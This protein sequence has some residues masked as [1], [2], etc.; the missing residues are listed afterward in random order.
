MSLEEMFKVGDRVFICRKAFE[1]INRSPLKYWQQ[2]INGTVIK[3]NTD[4]LYVE[5]PEQDTDF[6]GEYPTTRAYVLG[7]V[8]A[9]GFLIKK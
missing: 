8:G 6:D 5:W 2:R 9:N 7:E 1:R 3:I 4:Y